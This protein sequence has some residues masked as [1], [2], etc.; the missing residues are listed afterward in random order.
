MKRLLIISV[1]IIIFS[2]YFSSCY[3]DN[4]EV[5]YPVFG[6]DSINVTYNKNISKIMDGYCTGCHNE[7]YS[8]AGV[9]L[10]TYENVKANNAQI[11]DAIKHQ[12]PKSSMPPGGQLNECMILQW[13]LWRKNEMPQ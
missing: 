3:Y 9:I 13:D 6:C 1:I 11:N 4:E 8:E 5:L 12:G 10:T 7:S 2:L